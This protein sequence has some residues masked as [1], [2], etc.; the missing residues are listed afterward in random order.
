VGA[1]A[2]AGERDV[3]APGKTDLAQG[4]RQA[5]KIRD[6]EIDR[7]AQLSDE[8]FEQAMAELPEPT[9]VPT[10]EE[11]TVGVGH[12]PAATG[13]AP[14]VGG[15]VQAVDAFEEPRRVSPVLW[16]LAAA[17]ALVLG[18]GIANRDAVVAFFKGPARTHEP[19][20]APAREPTPA[21]EAEVVR[22]DAER[23]CAQSDWATC[24][25]NLDEAAKLD[26]AGESQ[27]GVQQMRKR[28][29]DGL[30]R[31]DRGDKPEKK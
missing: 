9:R 21:E 26:P 8:D 5:L 4:W 10:I 14:S 2:P 27:P 17:F 3:S 28:I 7:L 1:L 6:E 15:R 22:G 24:G 25:A 16:L 19:S 23:A 18:A 12:H 13:S 30:R 11:L 29:I 31:D 20:P